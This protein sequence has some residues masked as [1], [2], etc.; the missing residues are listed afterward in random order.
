MKTCFLKGMLVTAIALLMLS[1]A[2][3]AQDNDGCSV[4][5]LKGDYAFKVSGYIFNANGTITQIRD[6][7]AMTHFDGAGN[8]TQ[9]DYVLGNGVPQ[10]PPTAFRTGEKGTYTVN[11]DCTGDAEIDFPPFPGGAVIK[12]VFVLSNHGHTIHS[13]VSQLFPPG[14]S[15]PVPASIHSDAEKLGWV[16]DENE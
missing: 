9:V 6:G 2:A 4:A 12:L 5:T 11:M 16:R 1:A 14:S 15:T 13:V 10:G 7:I 3:W 8:L